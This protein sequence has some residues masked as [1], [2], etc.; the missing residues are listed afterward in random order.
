[1]TEVE[2]TVG[3]LSMEGTLPERMGITLVE[4]SPE[5]VVG[6]M[7]VAG[8]T[9]PYGLLHGGA[10]VVLAETLGSIGAA[11]HAARLFNG[12]AVGIEVNATHHKSARTGSVTGV[13]TPLRLGGMIASYEIVITDE[14]GERVCTARLTCALRRS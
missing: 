4:A 14:S 13:A 11:L 2:I 7:P 12:I 10:S 5:R 1:M 8:N 3:D 6:T 9:Q